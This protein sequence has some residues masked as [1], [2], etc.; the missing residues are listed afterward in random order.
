MTSGTRFGSGAEAVV[1]GMAAA[2]LGAESAT[3]EATG[4]WAGFRTKA[5]LTLGAAADRVAVTL[6]VSNAPMFWNRPVT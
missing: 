3:A 4:R 2:F 6:P 1:V 5:V